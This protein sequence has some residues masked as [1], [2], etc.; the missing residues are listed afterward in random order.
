VSDTMHEVTAEERVRKAQEQAQRLRDARLAARP[1]F[2]VTETD[3]LGNAH[4]TTLDEL[5]ERKAAREEHDRQTRAAQRDKERQD[6]EAARERDRAE[7]LAAKERAAET[8]RYQFMV[9]KAA[10]LD[11]DR[12]EAAWP[13]IE[14]ELVMRKQQT[15]A[16]DYLDRKR[17]E[18]TY[19]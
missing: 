8:K 18:G 7:L 12:F 1:D 16:E 15:G 5:L 9:W 11:P 13:Q 10:G 14:V 17:R 19:T 6:L 3:E 2:S 4:V